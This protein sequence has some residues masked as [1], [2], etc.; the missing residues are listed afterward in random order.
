MDVEAKCGSFF[1]ADGTF[2][3]A[4]LDVE[5]DVQTIVYESFPILECEVMGLAEDEMV[6]GCRGSDC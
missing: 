5:F 6:E 4:G 3:F 2:W 1:S